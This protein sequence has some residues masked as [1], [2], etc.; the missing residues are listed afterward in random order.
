[1]LRTRA[2]L[3]GTVSLLLAAV[4]AACGKTATHTSSSPGGGGVIPMPTQR[5]DV[6]TYKND[7]ARTGQNLTESVLTLTNVNP[8]RFGLERFLATD[9]KVDA[10]PLYLSGLTVQGATHNVVF[11]ATENDSVYAFDADSGALLWHVSV[12]AAGGTGNGPHGC[13][14]VVPVIGIT[15]TPVI[16]RAAGSHGT[17]YVVAMSNT[18]ADTQ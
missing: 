6:V 5:T 17:I 10:E 3:A 14:Q 12:L 13:D 8:A 16:D 15:S 18:G 9:G 11:V 4:L 1:M 2:S 7:A